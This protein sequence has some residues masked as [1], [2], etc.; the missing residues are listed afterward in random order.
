[1]RNSEKRSPVNALRAD[2]SRDRYFPRGGDLVIWIILILGAVVMLFPVYWM[3]ATAIRPADELFSR[4]LTLIPSELVW[5]NFV[6]A[7]ESLPFSQ[8]YVNSIIITVLAV[9]V[10]VFFDLLAGY[11]FAKYRFR[12]RD[13]MFLAML[14][15]LLIPIQVILV[16]TFIIA[17]TLGL[18]NSWWGVVLPRAS[19]VFGIFLVRQFMVSLPSE[20]IESARLD[21]VSEFGIFRK[22]ILPLSGP[23][24]AVL[25]ILIF[26]WRWNDFVW[27]LIVLQEESSYTVTLGLNL[28]KGE[29]W[30][31]WNAIMSMSLLSIIPVLIV[32]IVFQRQFIQGIAHTGLK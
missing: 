7:W 6:K 21:G 24:I 23:V 25:T 27:P 26:M 14:S 2:I 28:L 13:T 12:G 5:S 16:P 3:A 1:M 20:L 32:F 22:I 18:A 29:F 4:D 10:S 11:A 19:E 15:T 30:N 9:V 8:F 17:T 31:D